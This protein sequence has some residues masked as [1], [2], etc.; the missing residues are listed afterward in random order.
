M[1]TG[2]VTPHF[3]KDGHILHARGH[4]YFFIGLFHTCTNGKNI[5]FFVFRPVG[6]TNAARQIDKGNMHT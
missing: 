3:G 1:G 6:D 2:H 4:K 5:I